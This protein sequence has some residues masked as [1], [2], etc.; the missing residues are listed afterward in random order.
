MKMS[1]KEEQEFAFVT[2]KRLILIPFPRLHLLRVTTIPKDL[3]PS[4]R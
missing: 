3:K 2:S 4:L 1:S